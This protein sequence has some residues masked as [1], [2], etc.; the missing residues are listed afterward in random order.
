MAPWWTPNRTYSAMEKTIERITII[1]WDP[2]HPGVNYTYSD[3]TQ[4][5]HA[6]SRADWPLIETAQR[7]GTLQFI[8]LLARKRFERF[9]RNPWQAET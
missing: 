1:P 8:S 4:K 3:H 5:V 7:G 9:T 2:D 6:I